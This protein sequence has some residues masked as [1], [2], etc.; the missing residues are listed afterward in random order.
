MVFSLP[1]SLACSASPNSAGHGVVGFRRGNDALGAGELDAGGKG[2]E[3]LHAGRLDQS[4]FQHVRNQRRHAVIAQS[5]GMD[6]GRDE[7]GAERVHLDQR[8]EVAGVAEIVREGALGEA[9]AGGRFHGNHARVALSLDLAAQVGHDEAGEVRTA[10]GAADDHVGLVAGH[11]HLLDGFDADDGLV[12]QNV[13]QTRCPARTWC[14]GPWRRL[15]R[16][17]KWRCPGSRGCRGARREWRRPDSVSVLGLA[18]TLAPK[19][20]IRARR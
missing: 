18:V 8:G 14:W 7:G 19:A 12:Q 6:S 5:A 17:R 1:S 11:G 15:P 13:V 2:F 9:G 20:S 4:E 3:L 10:A 16:L